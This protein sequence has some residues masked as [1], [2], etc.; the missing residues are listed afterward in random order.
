MTLRRLGTV[1]FFSAVLVLVTPSAVSPACDL[2]DNN[3][4]HEIYCDAQV[5]PSLC[6]YANECEYHEC[7]DCGNGFLKN[8]IAAGFACMFK[9]CFNYTCT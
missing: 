5:Y 7:V 3:R 4:G 1:I 2:G 9:G 6:G 8:C